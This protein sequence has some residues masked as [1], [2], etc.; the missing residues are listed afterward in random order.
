[1]PQTKQRETSAL[2]NKQ[3]AKKLSKTDFLFLLVRIFE[4][5]S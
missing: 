1:M 5:M 3:V 2:G 4:V